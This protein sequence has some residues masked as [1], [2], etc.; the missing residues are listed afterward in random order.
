M[1]K[2][3]I[4]VGPGVETLATS[5][6]MSE[7]QAAGYLL[8]VS[9]QQNFKKHIENNSVDRK[10]LMS[11]RCPIHTSKKHKFKSADTSLHAADAV[12]KKSTTCT[13]SQIE[14]HLSEL[15]T[16]NDST[17]L[18]RPQYDSVEIITSNSVAKKFDCRVGTEKQSK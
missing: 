7:S 3:Y 13:V 11:M 15:A 9:D 4:G 1:N 2:S 16:T 6:K 17:I 14:N 12:G 5:V 8:I 10:W 18:E